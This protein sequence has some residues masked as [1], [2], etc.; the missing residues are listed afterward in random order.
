MVLDARHSRRLLLG[1]RGSAV[2]EVSSTLWS[3][4]MVAVAPG[5]INL[6]LERRVQ[7]VRAELYFSIVCTFMKNKVQII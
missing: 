5:D 4:V 2:S 1:V 6:N 3:M 7:L